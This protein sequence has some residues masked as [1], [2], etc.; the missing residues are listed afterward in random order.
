M[1]DRALPGWVV[2]LGLV[3]GETER[4]GGHQRRH[5]VRCVAGVAFLVRLDRRPVSGNDLL[6]R[7]TSGAVPGRLVM[8]G[9]AG[10]ALDHG[11]VGPQRHTLPVAVHAL[12]PVM[13]TM[14]ESDR[15]GPR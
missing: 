9:V 11:R 14:I 8:L 6:S 10:D 2:I 3:A 15:A 7:V 4:P 5:L 13:G 1:T 12:H